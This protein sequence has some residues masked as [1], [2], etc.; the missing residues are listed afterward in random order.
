M[1]R[2]KQ[3]IG[4]AAF[5]VVMALTVGF[6]SLAAD[7]G[8]KDNPLVTLDYLKSIEPQIDSV[9]SSAVT[10]HIDSQMSDIR[11][12]I[13]QAS[14]AGGM[15]S[16]SNPEELLQNQDFINSVANAI[17]GQIGVGTGELDSTA[18]RVT[19]LAGKTIFLA[20]GSSILLRQATGTLHASDTNTG[21]IDVTNGSVLNIGGTVLE[22]HK[23]FNSS[24][25]NNREVRF[26]SNVPSG[27]TAFIWGTYTIS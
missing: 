24:P 14:A 20:P 5:F 3:V 25:G 21:L 17:A 22:N 6:L 4:A 18:T 9:I 12:M 15:G 1:A 19:G 11:A 2:K 16:I 13:D 26:A 27:T 23:Y 7:N 10:R 8:G